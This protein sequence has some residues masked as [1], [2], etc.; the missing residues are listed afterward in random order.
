MS[1]ADEETREV[2]VLIHGLGRTKLSFTMMARALER[3]GFEVVTWGYSSTCC[4]VPEIGADLAE[5]LSESVDDE[6]DKVHFVGH[7]TGNI[8]VRW[9]LEEEPP[10]RV[11]H[12]V[13]LAPPNGGSEMA[14]RYADWFSWALPPL[15]DLTT[16]ESTASS[17]P[18]EVDHP[19]GIIA[20]QF[21]NKVTVDEALAIDHDDY[22]VV[23]AA[24]TFIM[25][26]PDVHAMTADFLRHGNF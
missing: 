15:A 4:T 20:G 14:D 21:D 1:V 22:R 12:V 19:V 23:G 25:N 18:A 5:S 11:G 9:L 16:S 10:T 3:E 7:S 13:M 2:V 8:V 17:L 6:H 26:R 24:H